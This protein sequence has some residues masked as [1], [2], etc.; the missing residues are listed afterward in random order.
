[1][2]NQTKS[3]LKIYRAELNFA[4]NE[5]KPPMQN[6]KKQIRKQDI[7]KNNSRRNIK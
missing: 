4:N 1:M 6:T 2:K 3:K 7:K 5:E